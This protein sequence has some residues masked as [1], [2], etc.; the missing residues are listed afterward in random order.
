VPVKKADGV[1]AVLRKA[2]RILD[3]WF[4]R[5][6]G[7]LRHQLDELQGGLQKLSTGLEKLE[8]DGKPAAKK[9]RSASST[10]KPSRPRKQKAA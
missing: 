8:H 9:A 2:D 5:G 3:G 6:A 10:R 1:E 4:R 7:A